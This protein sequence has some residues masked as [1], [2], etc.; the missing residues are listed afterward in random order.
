VLLRVLLLLLTA[1]RN[2]WTALFFLPDGHTLPP[3]T[4]PLPPLLLPPAQ[5]RKRW[6]FFAPADLPLLHPR[7]PEGQVT[8][9]R[10]T[11]PTTRTCTSPR[12]SE[13]VS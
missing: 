6:T 7:W 11:A 13:S 8:G 10:R 3:P 2:C 5:G 9:E 12:S 1:G 4:A